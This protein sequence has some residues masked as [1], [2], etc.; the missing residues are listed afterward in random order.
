MSEVTETEGQ[1][2]PVEDYSTVG[3]VEKALRKQY[4]GD[5]LVLVGPDGD[6]YEVTAIKPD[7]ESTDRVLVFFDEPA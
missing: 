4:T 5:I 7:D 3:G 6:E 2:K 1:L